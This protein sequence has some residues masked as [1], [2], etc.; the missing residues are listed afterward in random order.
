MKPHV[1]YM[2][3]VLIVVAGAIAARMLSLPVEPLDALEETVEPGSDRDRVLEFWSLYRKATRYRLDHRLD[4][5]T[6]YYRKALRINDRHEDAL[7]YLGHVLRELGDV[8]AARSNWRR[9][10]DLNPHSARAHTQLGL[11]ALCDTAYFDLE[12]A[13]LAFSEAFSINKEETG[14]LLRLGQVALLAGQWD[15][16]AYAFESVAASHPESRAAR[17][18]RGYVAWREGEA[19]EAERW[20]VNSL[21]TSSGT[22]RE[23]GFIGEGDTRSG[24]PHAAPFDGCAFFDRLPDTLAGVMP[25]DPSDVNLIYARLDSMLSSFRRTMEL[26]GGES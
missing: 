1:I 15:D 24:K 6:V 19:A 2:I 12:T 10:R 14:P 20:F 18:F 21:A 13:R 22:V 25:P 5:A 26:A 23:E 9:L 11:M 3:A 8:E 16:A 4:S 17:F 7:Y